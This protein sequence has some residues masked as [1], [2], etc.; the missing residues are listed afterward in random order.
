MR[1]SIRKEIIGNKYGLLTVVIDCG[2]TKVGQYKYIVNCD[3]GNSK[4]VV[5]SSL[6]TGATKSCGC[7]RSKMLAEKNYKHGESRTSKYRSM[8]ARQ[9]HMKRKLRIPAWTDKEAIKQFYMNKPEGF[10]VD[11]IIPL[12]GKYVSGLHVLENLQY[13]P[14]QENR[15]KNNAYEV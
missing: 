11:H 2:K 5:G 10:E 14:A 9:S 6:V 7:L 8:Q 12:R 1:K 15:L 3:C 4:V 13:L